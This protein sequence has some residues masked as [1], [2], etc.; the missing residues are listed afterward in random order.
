MSKAFQNAFDKVFPEAEKTIK[1]LLAP[2]KRMVLHSMDGG[3]HSIEIP[4]IDSR[5]SKFKKAV[6]QLQARIVKLEGLLYMAKCPDCD[7]S[8]VKMVPCG[9]DDV[10]HIMG[11]PEQCRWCYEKNKAQKGRQEMSTEERMTVETVEIKQLQSDLNKYKEVLERIHKIAGTIKGKGTK[12]AFEI[13][14]IIDQALKGTE[15]G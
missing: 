9:M 6:E 11:Q 7:G 10:G 5:E 8:G 2:P 4:E 1:E 3:I 14:N 15:N 13:W 12:Q